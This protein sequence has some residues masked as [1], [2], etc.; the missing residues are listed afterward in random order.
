MWVKQNFVGMAI[1]RD[2]KTVTVSEI[3]TYKKIIK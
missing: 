3:D 1:T 2:D